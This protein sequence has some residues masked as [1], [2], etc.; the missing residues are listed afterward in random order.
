[1]SAIEDGRKTEQKREDASQQRRGRRRR[2]VAA[3]DAAESHGRSPDPPPFPTHGISDGS[4]AHT[5]RQGRHDSRR[6]WGGSRAC[7]MSW[8][9]SVEE[10]LV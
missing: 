8:G 3:A 9:G 2:D 1:M 7:A 10:A 4:G 5:Y 6:R